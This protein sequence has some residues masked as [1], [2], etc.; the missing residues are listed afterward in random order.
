MNDTMSLS[1]VQILAAALGRY[2]PLSPLP[3]VA[4]DKE[5][6]VCA[7]S[8]DPIP[9]GGERLPVPFSRH[10]F[11]NWADCRG[12]VISAPAAL[13][14]DPVVMS[15]TQRAV[16][17][18]DGIY[19]LGKFGQLSGALLSPPAGPSVWVYSTLSVMVTQHLVWRAQVS[20]FPDELIY[21]CYGGETQTIRRKRVL[22]AVDACRVVMDAVATSQPDALVATKRGR[23]PKR[24]KAVGRHPFMTLDFNRDATRHAAACVRT[25]YADMARAAGHGDA[26]AL[27]SGMN[28]AEMWAL[29]PL[30]YQDKHPPVTPSPIPNP[31]A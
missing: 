14:L 7:L 20:P 19:P 26:V 13:A 1:A 9:K 8:G 5:A 31:I 21:L 17:T 3:S 25:E 27:L 30:L 16:I 29:V 15:A 22:D 28:A 4:A 24:A 10:S 23:K 2:A 18:P 6:T 11:T 12:E